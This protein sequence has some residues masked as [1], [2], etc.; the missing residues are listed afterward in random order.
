MALG[1]CRARERASAAMGTSGHAGR[2][3]D[4]ATWRWVDARL[5]A[6]AGHRRLVLSCRPW[7]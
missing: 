3:G 7:S 4:D 6:R 2:G 1:K 5:H